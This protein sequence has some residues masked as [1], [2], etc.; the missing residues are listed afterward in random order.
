MGFEEIVGG[1]F[2]VGSPDMSDPRDCCVYVVDVGVPVMIDT[3][4]GESYHTL[5]DAVVDAGFPSP[6]IH[7]IILTHCHIDHIGSAHRFQQEFG[8]RVVAH[9]DDADAIEQGDPQLT[10]SRWYGM[11][12]PPTRVDLR[13][14]GDHVLE[15]PKGRLLCIH[16]PG[17]TPG[18]LAV[19]YDTGKE[20]VLFGQDIHGPFSRT[21]RSDTSQWASSMRRLITYEADILCEGHFGIFR[22]SDRVKQYIQ[23]Y[24]KQ[25]GF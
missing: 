8:T 22:P 6:A 21:F 15:F 23:G 19:L 17:H 7:T 14:Q 2:L 11:D 16:T 25:Y 4:A 5:R 20:K 18:S 13:V 24:L 1:V 3:G 10:A 9:I 12:A